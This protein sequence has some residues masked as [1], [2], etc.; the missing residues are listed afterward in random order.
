VGPL[1]LSIL[2]SSML[3]STLRKRW[4]PYWVANSGSNSSKPVD[5]I[6]APTCTCFMLSCSDRSMA[7]VGHFSTQ[8]PHLVQDSQSIT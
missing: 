6:T 1:G 8:A 5:R 7:L 3:V 2:S 4:C